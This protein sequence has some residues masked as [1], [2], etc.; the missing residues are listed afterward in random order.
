MQSFDARFVA[1]CDAERAL[2][3]RL[4]SL[5]ADEQRALLRLDGAPLIAIAR[6]KEALLA[7][8]AE[9]G[10]ERRLLCRDAALTTPD[11]IA[12][13]LPAQDA[14]VRDAWLR[15]E[16]ALMRARTLNDANAQT[17]RE[18]ATMAESLLS[19]IRDTLRREAG[20]DR[21]GAQ[22]TPAGSGRKLGSA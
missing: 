2:L 7:E 15:L 9:Q 1:A 14:A 12:R 5:L 16:T 6:D 8:L 13:W 10:K 11:D 18:R 22:A 21:S 17:S 20:Y 3:E 4:A 19:E